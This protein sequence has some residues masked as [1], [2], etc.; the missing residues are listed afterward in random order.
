MPVL[1]HHRPR[2][3]S[4]HFFGGSGRLLLWALSIWHNQDLLSRC[5]CALPSR[6]TRRSGDLQSLMYGGIQHGGCPGFEDSWVGTNPSQPAQPVFHGPHAAS[7]ISSH[8]SHIFTQYLLCYSVVLSQRRII[9]SYGMTSADYH[10][11]RSRR[12]WRAWRACMAGPRYGASR[13]HNRTET[14][15]QCGHLSGVMP[16]LRCR[17]STAK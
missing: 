13:Y 14:E 8:G 10:G 15:N 4:K 1:I 11:S 3:L 17:G 12:G 2:T 5:T 7:D 6:N 9:G 16:Q